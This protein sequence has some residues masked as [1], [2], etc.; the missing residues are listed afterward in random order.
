MKPTTLTALVAATAAFGIGTASAQTLSIGS[1]PQGSLAYSTAAGIA[2]VATEATDLK[3]RVIPQGGPVVTLP[4]LNSGELDFTISLSIAAAFATEGRAMFGKSGKQGNIRV[5][6]ALFPLHLG[7]YVR[8]DSPIKTI[9]DLKGKRLGDKYPKQRVIKLTGL[10]KLATAGLTYKDVIGVPVPN[11]V[12]QVDDFM[13]GKIDAVTFSLTA[14]KTAQAH[15]KVG[16]IRV[17]SLP[18]TPE[19]EKAMQKVA[20]GSHI[21]TIMPN[22]AYPGV[23]GPTNIFAAPFL[24]MA[25]AKTSDEAVYKVVKAIH[26]N[27]KKL[28]TT[29]KAFNGM[30]P[31]AMHADVGVAYHPAALKFYKEMGM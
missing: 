12:R 9:A 18:K 23:M 26:A 8:N 17:L 5:V 10:A 13:A 2:K 16:G 14:G 6:A 7:F 11:G 24:L 22:P 3:V 19:S 27:K 20:P 30:Q 1:N 25:A 29:H 4:L 21:A 28:V 15:A 31:K